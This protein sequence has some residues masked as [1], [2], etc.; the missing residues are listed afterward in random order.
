MST[1]KFFLRWPR[2]SLTLIFV[3]WKS[4]LFTL[5]Q[6]SP[7]PGYDTSTVILHPL[8]NGWAMPFIRWDAIYFTQIAQRGYLFEQEW[9]FSWG[10]TRLMHIGAGCMPFHL[11]SKTVCS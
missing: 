2:L 4:L 3:C 1:Q 5:A 10:L 11:S 8:H 6:C 9:A 7:W